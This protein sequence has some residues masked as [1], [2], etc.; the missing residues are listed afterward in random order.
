[1]AV[2]MKGLLVG[3]AVITAGLPFWGAASAEVRKWA[4]TGTVAAV[5]VPSRTI[6]VEIPRGKD[7]LTVG[8]EISPDAVL[9]AEGRTIE[10]SEIKAGDRV[11]IE[12]SRREDGD[13]AHRI[14]VIQRATK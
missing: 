3:V 1:M 11:R 8:A 14:I 2:V 4:D 6:V 10:L 5:T 7:S 9:K 12:W 13:V